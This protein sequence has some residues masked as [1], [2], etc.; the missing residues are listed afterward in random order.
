MAKKE[1][2]KEKGGDFSIE[3]YYLLDDFLMVVV[4]D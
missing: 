4:G 2:V 3:K 1:M